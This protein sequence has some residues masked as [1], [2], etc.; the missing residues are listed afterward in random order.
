MR[1]TSI[2]SISGF[3]LP[4]I[5]CKNIIPFV[6]AGIIALL[7]NTYIPAITMFLPRYLH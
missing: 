2:R 7:I 5:L 6:V 4:S 1:S 3:S